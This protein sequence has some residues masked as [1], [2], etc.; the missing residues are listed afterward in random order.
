MDVNFR[1]FCAVQTFI[2]LKR[3]QYL[4]P[5]SVV[6]E[7]KFCRSEFFNYTLDV[8]YHIVLFLCLPGLPAM[9]LMQNYDKILKRNIKIAKFAGLLRVHA[10]MKTY[11]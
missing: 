4:I 10:R 1:I 5:D 3:D 8:V 9:T 11:V 6:L 7:R 2:C